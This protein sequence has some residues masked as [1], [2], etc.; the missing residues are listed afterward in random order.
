MFKQVIVLQP[1]KP[2]GARVKNTKLRYA[3]IINE[4]P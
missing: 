3:F 4:W 1:L 2:T